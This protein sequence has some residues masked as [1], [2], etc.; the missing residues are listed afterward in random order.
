MPALG[1]PLTRYMTPGLRRN[2]RSGLINLRL[3]ES[4]STNLLAIQ[5]DSVSMGVYR[6]R[7]LIEWNDAVEL[8]ENLG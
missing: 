8:I 5:M 2:E 4:S 6:I 3:I 1:T 7:N